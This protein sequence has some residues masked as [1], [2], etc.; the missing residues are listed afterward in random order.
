MHSNFLKTA[1]G[2]AVA[3]C[4]LA[5]APAAAGVFDDAVS[6]WAFDE[7]G[8]TIVDSKGVANMTIAD[9]SAPTRIAGLVGSGALQVNPGASKYPK[10]AGDV[11]ALDLGGAGGA[12]PFSVAGWVWQYEGSPILCKMENSGN[13]RGWWLQV[14]DDATNL[15]FLVRSTDNTNNKLQVTAKGNIPMGE[16]VHVAATYQYNASDPTRGVRLYVNG[17]LYDCSLTHAASA[18]P[19]D[20]TNTK[21][22]EFTA[23]DTNNYLGTYENSFDDMGVWNRV[24]S[25]AEIQQLVNAGSPDVVVPPGVNYIEN[26]DFENTTGWVPHG[27]GVL[28]PAGWASNLGKNNPADQAT[29]SGAIGGSGSSALMV[30]APPTSGLNRPWMSQAFI[31][32]TDPEWQF[33][34]DFATE[35]PSSAT[36]RT[37]MMVLRTNNGAQVSLRIT[38]DLATDTTGDVQVFGTAYADIPGLEDTVVYDTDLSNPN[39]S[40]HHLRIEGHFGDATP[41]YDITLTRPDGSSTTVTGITTFSSDKGTLASGARISQLEFFTSSSYGDWMID[42]VA[43]VNVPEPATVAALLAGM[44]LL[45]GWRARKR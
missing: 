14:N 23:R 16:W 35:A 37:L 4:C 31:H 27:A 24:L 7:T 21:P 3:A 12:G 9:A 5:A 25:Q 10:T 29:G 11:D 30:D 2:W 33:D 39:D 26:G 13:Y 19:L 38:N 17:S 8:N 1:F 45:L 43:L 6:Y 40:K 18:F 20:T 42:N 28:P 36:Q 44:M 34:M 32:P 22:F 15:N 41:N